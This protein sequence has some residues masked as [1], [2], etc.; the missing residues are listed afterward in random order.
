MGGAR[1]SLVGSTDAGN[2]HVKAVPRG[3]WQLSSGAGAIRVELPPNAQF[4]IDA[5][6]KSGE[7][8]VK[9]D[10]TPTPEA[11]ARQFHQAVNGGGK[12]IQINTD[13]GK[14]AIQ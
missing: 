14:I 1:G 8:V 11:A 10:D 9:R 7:I 4:E 13:G 6:T 3:D 5:T 12:H 2:L